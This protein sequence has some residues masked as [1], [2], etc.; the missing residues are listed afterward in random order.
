VGEYKEKADVGYKRSS[1]IT[2]RS[3]LLM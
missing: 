3:R 2:N 1:Q